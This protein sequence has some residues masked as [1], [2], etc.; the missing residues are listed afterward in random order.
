MQENDILHNSKIYSIINNM[1][2][3]LTKIEKAYYIYLELG[4]LFNEN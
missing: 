2:Q 1:P 4:K 3:G